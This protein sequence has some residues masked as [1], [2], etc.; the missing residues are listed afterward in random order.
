MSRIYLSAPDVRGPERELLLAA[1][2]SNW[3]APVGPDLDAFEAEVAALAGRAHGVGL[4]TGSAALHL[5]L[6][7]LGVKAGD[8]V[9]VSTFTFAA[10]AFAV[11]YCGAT[12]VFVDSETDSWNMSPDLLAEELDTRR[13]TNAPMP[14][15]AIVVDLYGQYA[16]Y[17]RIE[18]ILSEYGVA[19]VEDAAEAIGATHYGRPAGSFGDVGVFSF[20]GNKLITTSGGG[21]WSATTVASPAASVTW[22]PRLA[23]PPPTTSTPRSGSTTG[24]RTC[25]PP[26]VAVSSAASPPASP[27]APRSGPP[28][29]RPSWPSTASSSTPWPRATPSTTG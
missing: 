14:A 18:P 12:S 10:S 3:V 4:N 11:T 8:E 1:L 2:D 26:S 13:R 20:N 23:S 19:L 6:L 27:G 5:A 25:W 22:P 28:T 24:C 29:P 16:D 15:A 21:C 17:A 9:V 7:E